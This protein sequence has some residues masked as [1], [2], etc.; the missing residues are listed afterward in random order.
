MTRITFKSTK[1]N[2]ERGQAMRYDIISGR[3]KRMHVRISELTSDYMKM[4]EHLKRV[5]AVAG[6]KFR[7]S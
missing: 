3:S 2:L 5:L 4:E 1:T 6:T 7:A